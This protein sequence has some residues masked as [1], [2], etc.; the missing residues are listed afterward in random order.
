[1]K[2]ANLTL[3]GGL[4][5]GLVCSLLAG[6]AMA[7]SL[8][9]VAR[10]KTLV[11][12]HQTE[13]PNYRNVGIA[14]P[15]TINNEDI[16]GSILNMFEPLFYYN[17]NKD[18]LIP[19]LA[20]GFEYNDDFTEVTVKLRE[21][22]T[23]S[24]GEA[25]DAADVAFT[26]E[27]LR[28][29]GAGKKD[30]IQ[31]TK[32]TDSVASVEAVDENT[33]KF[34][35]TRPDPRFAFKFLINYFDIGFQIVPEHVWKDIE[36]KAAFTNFDL[37]KGW[38]LTTGPWKLVRFTDTQVFIDRRDDYW[39]AQSGFAD[40]PAMERIVTVPGGTRDRMAQLISANQ[41]DITA[42]IGVASVI[43]Q[44]V[45]QSPQ[46][47][48]FS[49]DKPPYGSKDWWPTSLYFNNLK[50]KWADPKLRHAINYYVNRDQIS[51]I[52][53]GGASE[54]ANTPFPGFGSLKPYIDAAQPLAEKYGIGVFD[55]AKGDALMQ[56]IGYAK[57]AD[58]MWEK[59]GEVLTV[60]IE[61]ISVLDAVA[62]VVSQQLRQAGIDA[63]FRST[64]ESRGIMRDG[65][66]DMAMF[67]H[68]GS[69][70]DPYA[71]L[72][73]YTC[74][75]Q[76]SEGQPT[77]F[78]DRWCDAEFDGLVEQIGALQPGDAK[79]LDLTTQA[80]EIWMR[81]AVEVPIQEWYH[82]IPMNTT[83]WTNWPTEENPYL[84]P[85]FWYTSGQFGYVM[86]QLEPAN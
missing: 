45:S 56:E 33:V 77:L 72:E 28:E 16:R 66:F 9:N 67:G 83:Y 64:P 2:L 31:A 25:F 55:Q 8:A 35:L 12:A 10:E 22:V 65:K 80:M 17:S 7:Q 75:N 57:N 47:S 49:G 27:M 78:M 23:W 53:Y 50:E 54:S 73:M 82:R 26:Y 6:T 46:I 5:G 34:T 24:D 20:E 44:I 11:V 32:V 37:E 59:D 36:D 69:I 43:K 38:P 81:E 85:A 19:W 13:A 42:D 48:T 14:N 1:M 62:P 15:Y 51:D 30:L 79:I 60:Q 71:T 39:A 40:L 63:S 61:T 68:R 21:G 76:L 29:N 74:K 3:L 70:S 52:V 84:Q 4:T 58:G 86:H 18:E 41:V